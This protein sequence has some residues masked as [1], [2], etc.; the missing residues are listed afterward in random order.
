[1]NA[2]GRPSPFPISPRS[3]AYRQRGGTCHT[4]LLT[5]RKEEVSLTRRNT[6]FEVFTWAT[7]FGSG[8][9]P[10]AARQG[11]SAGIKPASERFSQRV[12]SRQHVGPSAEQLFWYRNQ[13][14][15]TA[16]HSVQLALAPPLSPLEKLFEGLI[17]GFS[18][19]FLLEVCLRAVVYF[20]TETAYFANEVH[21]LRFARTAI[22]PNPVLDSPLEFDPFAAFAYAAH[23]NSCSPPKEAAIAPPGRL[24]PRHRLSTDYEARCDHHRQ[25]DAMSLA[26]VD[27][28]STRL[29]T[30]EGAATPPV[31]T[32]S[33][34]DAAKLC[35]CSDDTIRRRLR[36]NKL[37][38]AY[39]D[40]AGAG[41]PWR[42]P[43]IA[44]IEAGLCTR[45]VL[46][47]LDRHINPNVTRLHTE[48]LELR[49]E[50]VAE[51]MNRAAA[52]R[53]YAEV[54]ADVQY[55]RKTLDRVLSLSPG[56]ATTVRG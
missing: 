55:L 10:L 11:S 44:L 47:E 25:G 5:H 2:V 34:A 43:V 33:V 3:N 39:Q 36:D 14:L 54:F 22:A 40:G 23:R 30:C 26:T 32:V 46:D 28:I 41:A 7:T 56:A 4:K 18:L 48:F 50:L 37:R 53:M 1:M 13:D 45:S 17:C 12:H 31:R 21:T 8:Q 6:R 51:R 20:A 19:S 29:R 27:T 24:H 9:W 35:R 16:R 42:V 15:A 38:G 52:E 49:S